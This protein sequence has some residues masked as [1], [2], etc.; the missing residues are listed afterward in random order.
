MTMLLTFVLG[1]LD[2]LAKCYS[3]DAKRRIIHGYSAGGIMAYLFGLADAATYSGIAI[4]SADEGTAEYYNGG[5][6]LPSAWLIPVSH[7]H[8]MSDQNFPI[9]AAQAGID[10]LKAA[11]HPT[12]WHPIAG[13]HGATPT[14]ANALQELDDLKSYT[15][16]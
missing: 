2:D 4:F 12:Y 15:A 13:D 7:F 16:P 8:G 5:S 14:P 9:A 1:E 3:I 10:K 6:L 11:G